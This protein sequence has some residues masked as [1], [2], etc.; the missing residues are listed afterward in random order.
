MSELFRAAFDQET[1]RGTAVADGNDGAGGHIEN[2]GDFTKT[3]AKFAAEFVGAG[4]F[5]GVVFVVGIAVVG[6]VD[7]EGQDIVRIEAA[8]V[9]QQCVEALQ[10][11]AAGDEENQDQEICGRHMSAKIREGAG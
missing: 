2:A 6:Q 10:H 11:Q 9:S 3:I 7:G 1:D 5:A 4:V 8:I